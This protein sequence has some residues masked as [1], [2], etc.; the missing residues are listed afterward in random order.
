M[1][2][3]ANCEPL[4]PNLKEVPAK[5]TAAQTS[6]DQARIACALE[7]YR[8]AHGDFPES[9]AALVPPLMA[10]LP[11]DPIT[12][13]PYRYQRSQGGYRLYSV[14]W[15]QQDDHGVPG[16]SAFDRESGDWVWREAR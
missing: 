1:A 14:G 15:N 12:G 10:K 2:A 6:V 7:Q 3:V 16:P 9:L 5:A 4:L 11:T 8:L 13:E